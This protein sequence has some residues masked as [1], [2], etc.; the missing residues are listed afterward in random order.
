ML[1]RAV[2]LVGV[3]AAQ[4]SRLD[5]QLMTS[6]AY[7]SFADKA[8]AVCPARGLRYLHP[9]DLDGIEENFMPSITRRERHRVASLNRGD[10]GCTGGGASCP[11][12]NTLAAIS[13]AG[14]LDEFVQFACTSPI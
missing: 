11:A 7:Q 10:K 9:A 13:K 12:Q 3:L 1:L 2:V 6:A 5:F 14:L 4:P 8:D